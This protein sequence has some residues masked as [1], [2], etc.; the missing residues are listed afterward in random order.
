[1]TIARMSAARV[2]ELR[3]CHNPVFDELLDFVRVM[4]DEYQEWICEL[5]GPTPHEML[6]RLRDCAVND[7]NPDTCG[8]CRLHFTECEAE[9]RVRGEVTE[10]ACAGARARET[11]RPM[12]DVTKER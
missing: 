8:V 9:Q 4:S 2:R 6:A 10:A 7:D 12:G 3:E 5:E 1:M 11:L